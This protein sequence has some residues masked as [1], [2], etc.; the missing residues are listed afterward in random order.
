M[1][2]QRFDE[3]DALRPMSDDVLN[4]LL[5]NH[6]E[7]RR[8]LAKRVGSDALAEDLLQQS[9]A[10]AIRLPP[11]SNA[12]IGVLGWFYRILKNTLIDHYRAQA[13]RDKTIDAF[14]RELEM[15]EERHVPAFD[16]IRD[17]LCQCMSGLL[18]TL[19]PEYAEVLGAVDLGEEA[20]DVVADRLRITVGNLNVR[21]HRARAA[22]KKRL[23]QTCGVCTEHGC[24]SCTC[25]K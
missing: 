17:G 1:S 8:F 10:K 21:L 11:D 9:L 15:S 23:E 19:K 7:F 18:P 4:I 2:G 20:P 5:K 16:E 14:I 25:E 3:A 13:T 6:S 12:E 22:L 24:L